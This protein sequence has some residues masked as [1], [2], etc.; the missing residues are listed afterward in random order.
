[1]FSLPRDSCNLWYSRPTK[2]WRQRGNIRQRKNV[3]ERNSIRNQRAYFYVGPSRPD[4]VAAQPY[5]SQRGARDQTNQGRDHPGACTGATADQC[6]CQFSMDRSEPVRRPDLWN[7]G[8][9][10]S[11][12]DWIFAERSGCVSY[13][14]IAVAGQ[15]SS[16]ASGR[17][18]GDTRNREY[19]D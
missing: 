14:G 1:M 12:R 11:Y 5:S 4:G 6:E 10:D 18:D 7:H 16:G 19:F 8:D 9:D 13:G 2:F 15:G 3:S 17:G